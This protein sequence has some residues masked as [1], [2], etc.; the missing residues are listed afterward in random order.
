M[1][2]LIFFYCHIFKNYY[3]C[4]NYIKT[5]QDFFII[6][7]MNLHLKKIRLQILSKIIIYFLKKWS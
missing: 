4:L 5:T 2:L 6:H 1:I 3:R 7:G